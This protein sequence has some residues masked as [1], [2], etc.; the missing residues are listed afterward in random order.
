MKSN[1]HAMIRKMT[2]KVRW[3]SQATATST[4]L[5]TYSFRMSTVSLQ[6]AMVRTVIGRDTKWGLGNDLVIVLS[7]DSPFNMVH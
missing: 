6:A 2:N 1:V 7:R 3:V 5:L 4:W